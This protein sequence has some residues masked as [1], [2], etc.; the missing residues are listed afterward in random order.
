MP[1]ALKLAAV[2]VLVA[3]LPL[4][5]V[6]GVTIGFC[7]SGHQDVAV[8]AHGTGHAPGSGE[9]AHHGDDS[10]VQ[11]VKASCNICAEHCSNAAFATP[12]DPAFEA[13]PAVRDHTLFIVRGAPA[14]VP[15]RLDRPPLA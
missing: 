4:R 2:L 5:A 15:D 13:H 11:P 12:A 14:F 7:A 6:A 1:R 3:L 10:P 8:Q 9:H